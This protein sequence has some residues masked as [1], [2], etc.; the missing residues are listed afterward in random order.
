MG[1]IE[2]A[3]THSS[4]DVVYVFVAVRTCLLSRCLAKVS[5]LAPLFQLS[6]V[7]GGYTTHRQQGDLIRLL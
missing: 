6:G 2:K 3:A 1:L 4:F 5:V 7:R